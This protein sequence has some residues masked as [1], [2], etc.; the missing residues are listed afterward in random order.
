MENSENDEH[1]GFG[2]VPNKKSLTERESTLARSSLCEVVVSVIQPVVNMHDFAS[3]KLTRLHKRRFL[4]STK[5]GRRTVTFDRE[6]TQEITVT[7]FEPFISTLVSEVG[8]TQ[9]ATSFAAPIPPSGMAPLMR[10][11]LTNKG[12]DDVFIHAKILLFLSD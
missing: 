6:L 9:M 12:I 5:A 1:S 10:S 8:S 11:R 4:I 7:L 2:S 3:R